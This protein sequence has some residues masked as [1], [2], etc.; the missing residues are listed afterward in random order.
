[1]T[2]PIERYIQMAI[3]NGYK[4][5]SQH[6]LERLA[7]YPNGKTAIYII[8]SKKFIEAIARGKPNWVGFQSP[9]C[10][11]I[12]KITWKQAESIRDEKLDEFINNLLW[13]WNQN[14]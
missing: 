6:R 7:H 12:D 13:E 14:Y 2:K 8:T 11:D 4:E 9:F 5:C 3:E 1:M 10:R